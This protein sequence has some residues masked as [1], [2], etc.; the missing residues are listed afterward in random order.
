MEGEKS[1]GSSKESPK[2]NL[3]DMFALYIIILSP[4]PVRR[5]RGFIYNIR[6]KISKMNLR[7]IHG[8]YGLLHPGSWIQRF[9]FE[10][11]V[12]HVSKHSHLDQVI[13]L[14]R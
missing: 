5:G 3:Q 8:R 11:G 6:K 14:Q 13:G 4:P 7:I 1:R 12:V 2:R 9:G 10:S